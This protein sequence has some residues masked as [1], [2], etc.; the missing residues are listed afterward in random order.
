MKRVGALVIAMALVAGAIFIR[1]AL[2]DRN[3]GSSTSSSDSRATLLC[4][5]EVADA[6]RRLANTD[7]TEEEPGTTEARLHAGGKLGAD[8][9]VVSQPWPTFV[10]RRDIS[11]VL[12]SSPIV[13]VM[14]SE[15]A[16]KLAAACGGTI[17]W[18]CIG[19]HVGQMWSSFGGDPSWGEFKVGH[20]TTDTTDGF[21]SVVSATNG[22]FG[23][24]DYA[25]NDF[26]DDPDFQPWFARLEQSVEGAAPTTA[27]SPIDLFAAT[28][29]AYS[30]V[31]TLESSVPS[32][33]S[34]N[35][36]FRI[37]PLAPTVRADVVLVAGADRF[38]LGELSGALSRTGWGRASA[39][40]TSGLPN[41][42][43]MVALRSLQSSLTK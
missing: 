15:R 38:D 33:I 26:T 40:T 9:W 41:T 39:P 19:D 5:P 8:G 43:V 1:R 34:S 12:A 14:K 28:P 32:S 27:I 20:D 31:T 35:P 24:A 13:A 6:C 42:G 37:I 4:A 3:V 11:P 36:S 17:A 29:S 7:V 10:D 30:V 21:L 16:T 18:R 2:D 25:S 23:N 22:W